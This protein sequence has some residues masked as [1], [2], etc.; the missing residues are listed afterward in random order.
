MNLLKNLGTNFMEFFIQNKMYILI[1]SDLP[2]PIPGSGIGRIRPF[3][4]WIQPDID[5][6][7]ISGSGRILT[8][9][10]PDPDRISL[11]KLY[12]PPSAFFSLI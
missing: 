12:F 6:K 7:K 11:E 3:F 4:A 10:W 5:L 2:D 9:I 8:E 1:F